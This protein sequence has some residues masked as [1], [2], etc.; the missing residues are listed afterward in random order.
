MHFHIPGWKYLIITYFYLSSISLNLLYTALLVFVYS[1]IGFGMLNYI[2]H[3]QQGPINNLLINLFAP[4]EGNHKDHHE[5][6]K[7]K[8]SS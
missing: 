7:K 8:I 5:K 1:Y 3:S 2:G 6:S 4:F